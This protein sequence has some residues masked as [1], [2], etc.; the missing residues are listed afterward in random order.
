MERPKIKMLRV[1]NLQKS[2][3]FNTVLSDLNL[4]VNKGEIIH[5]SGSN[6]AGKTTLL[7]IIARIQS[8][9]LGEVSIFKKDLLSRD[10]RIVTP[11]KFVL[12]ETF[13]AAFKASNP[14]LICIV[15]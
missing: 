6:G 5:I 12:S 2:F 13:L 4:K 14:E 1:K 10:V 11:T 3:N 15:R 7:K 9:E 8:P